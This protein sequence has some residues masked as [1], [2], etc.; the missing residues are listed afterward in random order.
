M[1]HPLIRVPRS[2]AKAASLSGSAGSDGIA[3]PASQQQAVSWEFEQL[4]LSKKATSTILRKSPVYL[5]WD[6]E[7]DLQPAVQQWQDEV[8]QDLEKALRRSPHLL[9][10]TV[11]ARQQHY[12]WLLSIGVQDPQKLIL[13]EPRLLRLRVKGLQD[14]VDALMA[15]GSSFQQVAALLEQH[16]RILLMQ[17]HTLQKKLDFV[18]QILE[19]PVTSSEVFDFVMR[20]QSSSCLFTSKVEIQR[21]GMAFL[22]K[23]GVS[24]KGRAKALKFNVCSLSP[25]EMELR[26]QY[27]TDRLGLNTGSLLS[28]LD[29]QPV[30]LLLQPALIDINLRRLEARGFS[31]DQV[32]N[33]AT[34]KPTLLT[35]N[36]DTALQQEKWYALTSIVHVP[37]NRLVRNP[38]ILH[39][40]LENLLARWQ[41]LS[42]LASVGLL[43]NV[44]PTDILCNTIGNSDKAFAKALDCP[45]RRLVYNE[46]FKK[47]CL[48]RY[49]PK[50][51][52]V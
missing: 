2:S 48:A 31:A 35:A 27:L 19:I 26:C 32:K 34:R 10:C 11:A 51:L 18:A 14:K 52:D 17:V 43:K 45:D 36:W 44:S 9:S 50:F 24:K 20:V 46:S 37:L 29:N 3:P 8:G 13:K 1:H 15:A 25:C 30:A 47:A 40:G 7:H 4:G 41:F 6:I 39:V 12:S 5:K 22:Q 23:M 28:I 33:M 21:E 16:P 42:Q 49:V 38:A